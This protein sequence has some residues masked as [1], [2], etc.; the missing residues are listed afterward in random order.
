MVNELTQKPVTPRKAQAQP[1]GPEAPRSARTL[2]KCTDRLGPGA[3][4][5]PEH[6][7]GL[8]GVGGCGVLQGNCAGGQGAAMATA[9]RPGDR[10]QGLR[11]RKRVA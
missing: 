7:K 10:S 5:S 1:F 2:Q 11:T 8:G 4:P 3:F 9:A 6:A